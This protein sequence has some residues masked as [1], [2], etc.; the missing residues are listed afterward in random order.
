V[1]DVCS[2]FDIVANTVAGNGT[3][4]YLD[5]IELLKSLKAVARGVFL[6]NF[7]VTNTSHL[8]KNNGL[9]PGSI[10]GLFEDW[11]QGLLLLALRSNLFFKDTFES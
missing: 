3:L 2:F 6:H 7:F 11:G 8:V 4:C 5:R 9:R 10:D 1:L